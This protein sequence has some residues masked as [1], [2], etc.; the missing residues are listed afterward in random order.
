MTQQIILNPLGIVTQPN[1]LGSIPIGSLSAAMSCR[2]RDMG[3]IE[4][5][6]TW[7]AFRSVSSGWSGAGNVTYIIFVNGAKTL[8][9]FRSNGPAPSDTWNYVWS[10]STTNATFLSLVLGNKVLSPV[11]LSD[12][13]RVDT[14]VYG[15]RVF[16][17]ADNDTIVFP[18]QNPATT[19]LAAPRRAGLVPP[20]IN[21]LSNYL[22]ASGTTDPSA[23]DN[24][25]A[26]HATAIIR[27]KLPNG[28]ELVSAPCAAV[29]LVNTNGVNC[30]LQLSAFFTGVIIEDGDVF[31]MYRTRSQDFT[32]YVNTGSDY[33]LSTT[34][35][36]TAGT[37]TINY[38]DTTPDPNLGQALYTN[39]GVGGAAAA[40]QPPPAAIAACQYKGYAFY[41]GYTSPAQF[42]FRIPVAWGVMDT[43][44]ANAIANGIGSRSITGTGA[45]GSPTITAIPAS[46]GTSGFV[47]GQRITTLSGAIATG[48]TVVSFTSTSVTFSANSTVAGSVTLSVADVMTISGTT[49]N[50]T[51]ADAFFS[52]AGATFF[53]GQ[54][55]VPT[56]LSRVYSTVKWNATAAQ[57]A[58]VPAED[59]VFV[60][61]WMQMLGNTDMVVNATNGQNYVPALP[62][63]TATG[64][65]FTSTTYKNGVAWSE[66][67][68]PENVPGV[69]STLIGKGEIYRA[70][71]LRD[72]IIIAAS[73]GFWRLSGTGGSA[74]E[75]FDWRVDPLDST[76]ILS[77]PRAGCVFKDTFYGYTNRGLVSM[78]SA[79]TVTEFSADIVNDLLPGPP[80]PPAGLPSYDPSNA[81]TCTADETNDEILLR[82]P[83]GTGFRIWIFNTRTR[84]FVNDVPNVTYGTTDM[85]YSRYRQQ[86]MIAAG[87]DLASI[88]TVPSTTFAAMDFE[89]QPVYTE[90]P[91]T[92]KRW[93]Q[94]DTSFQSTSG[95]NLSAYANGS[96]L[97]GS[98]TAAASTDESSFSR[99]SFGVP[100]AAPAMANNMA[101]RIQLTSATS[102][103]VRL[104]GIALKFARVSEQRKDR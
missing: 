45:I 96:V 81:I 46:P 89:F 34:V 42:H 24:A 58:T 77:G 12:F 64:Q 4:N 44:N 36:L 57:I 11:K 86:V 23:I 63:L 56:C 10:D 7:A 75:G 61:R 98:R 40:A 3:S 104:Q 9:I 101:A 48:S 60:S 18:F 52:N 82:E 97:M 93:Q 25:K 22:V 53:A 1:A 28:D 62:A 15:D 33:F 94:L 90:D 14:F 71:S 55:V 79:G 16:V 78:D 41:F 73:D 84:T 49:I 27:R 87:G 31:E 8:I 38:K 20:Q 72:C 19:A 69:N 70:F 29:F 39:Q 103:R 51:S 66:Q 37:N 74:G 102:T 35:T 92:I 99:T 76:L 80:W 68:Q 91:F 5:G 6:P 43:S 30:N 85:V 17:T 50:M 88:V 47:V 100:V 2:I 65:T 26:C 13:G 21:N 54:L 67:G 95:M 83:L 59:F 32:T